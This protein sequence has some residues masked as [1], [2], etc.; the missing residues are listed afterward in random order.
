MN[1]K[2]SKKLLKKKYIKFARGKK[3]HKKKLRNRNISNELSKKYRVKKLN[4]RKRRNT[5]LR[6]KSYNMNGGG[7][8]FGGTLKGLLG[9]T[10]NDETSR[11]N[12][13]GNICALNNI[14]PSS[15]LQLGS[16]INQVCNLNENVK[17]QKKDSGIV[18][19]AI[20]MIGNVAT[21]PLRT[22]TGVV[23]NVTGFDA[24]EVAY[25]A[26][27]NSMNSEE[28]KNQVQKPHVGGMPMQINHNPNRPQIVTGSQP[29]QGGNSEYL[30]E[31]TRKLTSG[32]SL[33]NEE[34]KALRY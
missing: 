21:L 27:K 34:I 32:K 17:K 12:L 1:M 10:H 7:I 23:K 16:L 3:S 15:D 6:R 33:T 30:Q 2:K 18:K 4:R 5:R 31:L 13:I 19:G 14:K 26:I 25:N 22:A 29:M 24:K 20:R 11:D 28:P 9:I 8:P